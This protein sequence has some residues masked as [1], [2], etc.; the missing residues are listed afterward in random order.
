[1]SYM[2]GDQYL[3]SDG[4]RLH[5]WVADGHDGWED[6]GWAEAVKS[7]GRAPTGKR[8]AMPPSR[9]S[10]LAIPEQIADEFVVMRLAELIAEGR[11]ETAI[12]QAVRRHRGNV[13]CWELTA[14]SVP[15]RAALAR[16]KR[17]W[18]PARKVP[19]R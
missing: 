18:K 8:A 7:S 19:A 12:R 2:R 10:G 15:L 17:K 5:I 6:S 1:M 3:R 14:N 16:L 13:G 11:A 9:P 4:D